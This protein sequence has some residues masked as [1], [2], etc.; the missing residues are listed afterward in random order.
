MT[1]VYPSDNAL[2][3]LLSEAET[4]VEYIE[5]GKAPYYLEFRKLLQRLLLATRRGND[6]RVFDEGGLNVG[7]KGGSFH[8]SAGNTFAYASSTGNALTDN[9][10]NYLYLDSAGVLIINTTG[11]PATSV[12]HVRL[13]T[14][15]TSNAGIDNITDE[16]GVHFIKAFG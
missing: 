8:D 7:V 5:T 9:A 1:E 11:F 13:A 16:R 12:V 2:L 4:G 6:L 3:N 14:V 15:P 10:T